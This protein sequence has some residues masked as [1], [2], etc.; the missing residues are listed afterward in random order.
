MT[1]TLPHK[2][3]RFA[4]LTM[5]EARQVEQARYRSDD[6][7][8]DPYLHEGDLRNSIDDLLAIIDRLTGKGPRPSSISATN[9]DGG[10]PTATAGRPGDT[11]TPTGKGPR[12]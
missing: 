6:Y 7:A 9:Y 5:E 8:I 2:D 1:T 11:V 12:P 10:N 4:P 3:E